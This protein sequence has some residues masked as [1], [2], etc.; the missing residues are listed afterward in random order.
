MKNTNESYYESICEK[1]QIHI[2]KEKGPLWTTKI[3]F[4][5]GTLIYIKYISDFKGIQGILRYFTGFQGISFR[6]PPSQVVLY[7]SISYQ[8]FNLRLLYSCIELRIYRY[9]RTCFLTLRLA[10]D[11][12]KNNT[13]IW[14]SFILLH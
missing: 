7:I 8:S 6:A 11:N 2:A 10:M 5:G 3:N 12:L 13:C 14:K 9:F 1:W 4:K